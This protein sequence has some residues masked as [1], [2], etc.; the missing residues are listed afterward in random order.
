MIQQVKRN[1][2]IT[3]KNGKYKL[4]DEFPWNYKLHG[5]IV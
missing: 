5:I 4:T 1:L 3:D 2:I